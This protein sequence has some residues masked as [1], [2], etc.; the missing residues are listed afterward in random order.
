[1][2]LTNGDTEERTYENGELH[3]IATFA[4]HN[5]DREE[6]YV[7]IFLKINWLAVMDHFNIFYSFFY[8]CYKSGRLDGTAKY[9]YTSGA[10]ESRIYENGILQG[11]FVN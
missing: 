6:R 1:L 5:G 3:G 2:Y 7:H 4:S 11:T 8:R 9:Y 10:V